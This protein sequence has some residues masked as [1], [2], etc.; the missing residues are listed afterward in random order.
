MDIKLRGHKN[1]KDKAV[2]VWLK[3]K[4]LYDDGIEID[5]IL[6][7]VKKPDGSKYTRSYFHQAL[8]KLKNI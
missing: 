5:E 8:N 4:T 1:R 2:M 7:I 6:N 3:F